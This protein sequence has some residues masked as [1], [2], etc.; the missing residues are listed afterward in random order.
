MK[1]YEVSPRQESINKWFY[2]TVTQAVEESSPF[3]NLSCAEAIAAL[4]H[5]IDFIEARAVLKFPDIID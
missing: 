1:I 4:Q 5:T 3:T 2:K